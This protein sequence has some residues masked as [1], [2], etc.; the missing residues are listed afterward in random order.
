[1][2]NKQ[3]ICNMLAQALK[4]TREYHDLVGLTYIVPKQPN[5]Y[6]SYVVARFEN[7]AKRFI[8]T[9]LD[10]GYAMIRDIISHI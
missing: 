9:S 5:K 1:M 7:G 10:S 2:E 6:E 3:E 8:N 4:A